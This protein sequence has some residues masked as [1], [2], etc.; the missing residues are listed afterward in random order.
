MGNKVDAKPIKRTLVDWLKVLVLLL[1]EA[2]VL[3]LVI[4]LLRFFEVR[5]PLPI[6]I[7]IGLL[8]G[9]LIFVIHMAVIPTF[10][11]RPVTGSEAMIGAEGQVVEPLAPVGAIMVNGECWKAKSVGGNIA[12]DAAVEIVGRDGLTLRVKCKEEKLIS[13]AGQS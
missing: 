6:A 13:P 8:V 1:D 4:L 2:V 7:V 9:G 3:V 5:I 12:V 11:Q 10:H